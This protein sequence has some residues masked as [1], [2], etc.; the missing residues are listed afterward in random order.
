MICAL[1]STVSSGLWL[2]GVS[3]YPCPG[4]ARA[5]ACYGT[6]Q[7]DK[8]MCFSCV[9]MLRRQRCARCGHDQTHC[10]FCRGWISAWQHTPESRELYAQRLDLA[11]PL[12]SPQ[13]AQSVF[14]N[15]TVGDFWELLDARQM[16][17]SPISEPQLR[18]IPRYVPHMQ[19]REAT[20]APGNLR[21]REGAPPPPPS[22]S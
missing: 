22:R 8:G 18:Q 21:N 14:P 20:V 6:E 19:L 10:P 4:H 12:A 7:R 15:V 3:V 1:C 17:E 13:S 16:A 9:L 2:S 11:V 5:C